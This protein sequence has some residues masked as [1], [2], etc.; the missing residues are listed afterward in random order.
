MSGRCGD[1]YHRLNG[2]HELGCGPPHVGSVSS[3][4]RA[5]LHTGGWSF[6]CSAPGHKGRAVAVLLY[7]SCA[8]GGPPSSCV[9]G[10]V[11]AQ[12]AIVRG[13]VVRFVAVYQPSGLDSAPP[14]LTA[15]GYPARP[16]FDDGSAGYVR[17]EGEWQ[18]GLM[19]RHVKRAGACL[20]VLRGDFNETPDGLLDRRF[21]FC[22]PLLFSVFL[23]SAFLINV[24]INPFFGRNICTMCVRRAGGFYKF[25]PN[26][27]TTCT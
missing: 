20:C 8:L 17:A 12:D 11:L 7:P 27:R 10:G 14:P 3:D 25:G 24:S 2:G 18:R 15:E 26:I 6:V 5:E 1:G 13:V 21:S 23:F 9:S 16:A 19:F 4:V 22:F